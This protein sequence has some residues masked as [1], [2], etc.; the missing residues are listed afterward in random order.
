MLFLD[1]SH[2]RARAYIE[3]ARSALAERQRES[4]ELLQNGVAAFERGDGDEARRLLAGGDRR[5][6][7]VGR[8]ARRARSARTA[9]SR[10]GAA[11]A[12][13]EPEP[14]RRVRESP[15]A[16]SAERGIRAARSP[17]RRGDHRRRRASRRA[18]D[19]A[20]I[21]RRSE[22]APRRCRRRCRATRRC[23]CRAAA[24]RRCARP[25][26]VGRRPPARR[27]HRAR[28]RCGRPIRS[29]RR[30]S[31]SRRHPAAAAGVDPGADRRGAGCARSAQPMK[32]PKCGYLGFEP[33]RSLP[34]LSATISRCRSR[35]RCPICRSG[36]TPD[37]L[38]PLDD[39]SLVDAAERA[40]RPIARGRTSSADLDRMFGGAADRRPAA[41]P[42][43]RRLR[44]VRA[45]SPRRRRRAGAARELPL[46]GAADSR[47]RAAD[48]ERVAAA[49]AAGGA[50]GDAGSAA[51]ARRV[52]HA[53]R[54]TCDLDARL[55]GPAPSPTPVRAG[56][57]RASARDR[58][59]VED[60]R[61]RGVGSRAA[62]GADRSRRSSRRST[63]WSSTSRCR[64]AASRVDDL[65]MLPKGPLLAFLLVQNGGYL[66]AF[67]AGGQT[68]GKMAARHPGRAGRRRRARSISAARCM[69]TLS[70][71]CWPCRPASAF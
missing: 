68:L 8:G 60:R 13:L 18:L 40:T 55:S 27:A 30:R 14:P 7:A 26:A 65:G 67:T 42:A 61:M 69:R 19:G 17:L 59:P 4:E 41:Q 66:V 39:L 33:R 22:P 16:A 23:R 43:D 38:Q 21:V 44:R 10:A 36:A 34:Q 46:F 50:P 15:T 53:R 35:R 31:A 49:A 25:R 29:G 64:S 24:R 28:S 63:S 70:G 52:A 62:R 54:S 9:S 58:Q 47:R 20:A 2:A 12:I 6:R 71:S 45:A 1:R 3:R 5:R 32:C 48:Y 11:A 56:A 57:T 51:A 37:T